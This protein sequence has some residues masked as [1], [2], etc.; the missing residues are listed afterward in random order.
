MTELLRVADLFRDPLSESQME[1]YWSVLQPEIT[2]EE[3]HYACQTVM[4]REHFPKVPLPAVFLDYALEY[5][6]QLA[7]LERDIQQAQRAARGLPAR[8]MSQDD[9]SQAE[10]QAILARIWPGE[11]LPSMPEQGGE[12]VETDNGS[13][14]YDSGRTAAEEQARKAY[15]RTQVQSS[16]EP[17][18]A[19]P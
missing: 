19:H 6:A 2:L 8:D 3:W 4:R 11:I 17:P 14:L 18:P 15:L 10:V 13:V 1:T 7:Q 12:S 9:L 5:R 16:R